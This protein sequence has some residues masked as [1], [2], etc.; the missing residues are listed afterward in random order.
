MRLFWISIILL[1][2]I[3]IFSDY[4]ERPFDVSDTFEYYYDESYDKTLDDGTQN[5]ILLG[6][7]RSYQIFISPAQGEVCNF[8]PSCSN[9]MFQSIRKYG[10]IYG[11]IKGIDRLQRCNF[12]A[13]HYLGSYY[14]DMVLIKKRGYKLIDKP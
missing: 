1:I 11:L 2:S 7:I 12:G 4:I 10:P 14:S 13:R 6:L 5:I 9:Y 8:T 3:N